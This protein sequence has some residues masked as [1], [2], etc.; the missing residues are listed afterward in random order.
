V[1]IF[2]LSLAAYLVGAIVATPIELHIRMEQEVCENCG[3]REGYEDHK[4]RYHRYKPIA[5]GE[6]RARTGSDA[7][8]AFGV[9]LLWPAL[10][11]AF[12]AYGAVT[13]VSALI[14]K[15]TKLTPAERR[16]VE[17]EQQDRIAK[18]QRE[19]ARLTREINGE[20]EEALKP[21][22]AE[23]YRMDHL[24]PARRHNR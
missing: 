12:G 5:R 1:I 14:L 3:K 2:Y 7:W 11:L 17:R 21:W 16:R 8:A 10:V 22:R 23:P 18:Q 4:Y 20:D 24:M 15:A 9:A 13:G 19:I 6:E